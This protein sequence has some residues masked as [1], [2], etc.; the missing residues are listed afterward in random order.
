MSLFKKAKRPRLAFLISG[1]GSNMQAILDAIQK[2]KLKA[3][4]VLVFSDV[5]SAKGLDLARS[6]KIPAVSFSPK[7]FA[8]KDAYEQELA[9]ILSAENIDWVI[10]AGYMRILKKTFID[11]FPYQVLNIHPSLL[12]SFPGL[13]AQLQ[14][15]EYGVKTSGCTIHF[16]DYGMDTGPIIM[17]TSVPV[18]D[19]DDERS[20]SLRILKAEHDSYWKAI[21]LVSTKKYS[22]NGRRIVF[23]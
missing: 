8:T 11:Q 14:A 3:D 21:Q 12:P 23:S 16:V 4:P 9:K 20:L 6:Q 2:K 18:L 5:K 1:R 13:K 17:Q 19:T 10:C 7:E 22:I 15:L